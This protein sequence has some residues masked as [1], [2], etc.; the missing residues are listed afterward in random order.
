VHFNV[1][2]DGEIL[3]PTGY[4]EIDQNRTG[5]LHCFAVRKLHVVDHIVRAN[6]QLSSKVPVRAPQGAR[7]TGRR[8]HHTNHVAQGE[9]GLFDP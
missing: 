8:Y 3:V 2:E 7:V 9:P 6:T 1:D 5:A 4:L